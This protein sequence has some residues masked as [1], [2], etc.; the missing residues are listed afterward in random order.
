MPSII[1]SVTER[2]ADLLTVDRLWA[3]HSNGLFGFSSQKEVYQNLGNN[4]ENFKEEVG[5]REYIFQDQKLAR[6]EDLLTNAE[7][8]FLP[9]LCNQKGRVL[10]I[11][12][13]IILDWIL[14]RLEEV[15]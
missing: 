2:P 7:K 4:L 13:Q 11:K 1:V 5:W 15:T 3:A 12:D 8:G 9:Y 6:D 10:F 14:K